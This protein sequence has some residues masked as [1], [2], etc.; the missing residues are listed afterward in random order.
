MSNRGMP[1]RN[2]RGT[3]PGG[4]R[5]VPVARYRVTGLPRGLGSG[6]VAAMRF[7]GGPCAPTRLR[8]FVHA[9]AWTLV[10]SAW[11][12]HAATFVVTSLAD[13]GPGTL[14]AALL[15]ADAS[16]GDDRIE[17]VVTGRVGLSSSLPASVGNTVVAG[18]GA[19]RL[20]ISPGLTKFLRTLL[21]CIAMFVYYN[22]KMSVCPSIRLSVC[23]S[24]CL[25]RGWLVQKRRQLQ[26]SLMACW[27][28][29]FI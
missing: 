25:S 11:S 29:C 4:G 13:S 15:E 24:V 23:L 2:A 9:F 7:P 20:T 18:P 19:D 22:G 16:P 6:S 10:G 8:W 1:A 12:M 14:R 17:F 5:S 28:A 21:L 27:K 3:P 26:P